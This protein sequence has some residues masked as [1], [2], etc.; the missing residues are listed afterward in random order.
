MRT[1]K[2]W[3]KGSVPPRERCYP[4]ASGLCRL[5]ARHAVF[6][7]QADK[8]VTWLTKAAP[9]SAASNETSPTRHPKPSWYGESVG[10]Y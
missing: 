8:Q 9:K 3:Q 1:T 7:I 5:H 6:F 10:H 4:E 2:C